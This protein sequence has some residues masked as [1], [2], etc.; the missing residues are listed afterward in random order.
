MKVKS[1]I[2]RDGEIQEMPHDSIESAK[3]W[4]GYIE[5]AYEAIPLRIVNEKGDILLSKT[6]DM[7]E[8]W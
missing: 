5:Y 6:E 2:F 3:K 7:I 4:N 1:V 8:K